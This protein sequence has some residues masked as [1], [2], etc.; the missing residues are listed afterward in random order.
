MSNNKLIVL[1]EKEFNKLSR[2]SLFKKGGTLT[3]SKL[4]YCTGKYNASI[5]GTEIKPINQD[6]RCIYAVKRRD[7][8]GLFYQLK[9][10]N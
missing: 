9:S 6:I 7:S 1:S 5:I 10:A 2:E 4:K 8:D 3:K